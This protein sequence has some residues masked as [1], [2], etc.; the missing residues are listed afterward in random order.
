MHL[1]GLTFERLRVSGMR[2][3]APLICKEEWKMR[4]GAPFTPSKRPQSL[5]QRLTWDSMDQ[6]LEGV[7]L[8]Y[9]FV[10]QA[11]MPI[12]CCRW[13]LSQGPYRDGTLQAR[14]RPVGLETILSCAIPV[15]AARQDVRAPRLEYPG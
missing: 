3:R 1:S 13:E 12:T 14:G 10:A 15:T 7:G 11:S 2:R 9:V 4:N 8:A 5:R 6:S